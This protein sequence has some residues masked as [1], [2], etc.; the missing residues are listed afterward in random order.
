MSLAD[1]WLAEY[2]KTH[3]ETDPVPHWLYV[4]LATLSFVGLLWFAPVPPAFAEHTPALNWGALLLMAVVVYYFI[5]SMS[6]AVGTLPFI[7][8]AVIALT[9]LERLDVALAPICG[10]LFAS[11]W[12]GRCA[13]RWLRSR[14]AFAGAELQLLMIGPL[15]LLARLYRRLGIP[16]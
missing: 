11:L 4:P 6:L 10:A 7:V 8:L 5:V 15:W 12:L 9:W 13:L 2:S 1:Q 16:Y 14:P 3:A